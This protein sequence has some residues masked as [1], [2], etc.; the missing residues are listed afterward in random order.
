MD[1]PRCQ[2]NCQPGTIPPESTHTF[3]E[4]SWFQLD[5]ES[6][7]ERVRASGGVANAPS[8]GAS[9]IRGIVGFTL[10]SVAGFA[11]WALAGRWFHRAIG[12]AGLYILCAVVFIG[13]GGLLLHR[14]II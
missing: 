8:L 5:P 4:M 14:L 7:A 13:L 9:L 1:L 6:I 10:V 12:E 11:P 2:R 3:A